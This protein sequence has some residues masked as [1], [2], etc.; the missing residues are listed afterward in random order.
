MRGRFVVIEGGEG[1]GKDANIDLLKQDFADRTDI[2]W[3]KDP[4]STLLGGQLRELLQHG[5]NISKE[6]ELFMFMAARAQLVQEVIVPALLSGK[7]VIS[8]RFDL[9]TMAY[10]V[11]GR[12]RM[13]LKDT[14]IA[15]SKIAMGDAVPDLLVLLDID[16][17]EGLTRAAQRK[18]K[19]T[20]FE[21][22]AL[23]FHARVREGYHAHAGD[24]KNHVIIDAARPLPDVYA[25]VKRAVEA[26]F[27]R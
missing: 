20:R 12:E 22:E 24:Y 21:A 6:A 25:D 19:T 13:Q 1:A 8:N 17:R 14:L 9:S 26:E 23:A 5:E 7:H 10:Q 15:M 16:P 3:V 18:E 4:G 11:Y 27:A 2:V